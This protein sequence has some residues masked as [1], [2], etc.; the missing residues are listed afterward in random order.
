MTPSI[1]SV[2]TAFTEEGQ[3]ELSAALGYALSLAQQ[4]GA[5]LTIQAAAMR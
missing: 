3:G 5:H 2:F 4:A 1:K